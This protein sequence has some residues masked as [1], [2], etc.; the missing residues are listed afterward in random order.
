MGE[1]GTTNHPKNKNEKW[2]F[3]LFV[4]YGPL[5]LPKYEKPTQ[6]KE[7][8]RALLCRPFHIW[9]PRQLRL[10]IFWEVKET[11]KYKQAQRTGEGKRGTKN[12]RLSR[13]LLFLGPLF[14]AVPSRHKRL[15][16]KNQGVN[17]LCREGNS[18][19]GHWMTTY[20]WL[21]VTFTSP[22]QGLTLHPWP[23]LVS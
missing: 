15:T 20:D 1:K 13:F 6:T 19:P 16:N 2:V 18:Q 5:F 4:V 9:G 3:W 12:N 23:T 14:L 22:T 11:A 21:A 10:F 8:Q 7:R 17:L